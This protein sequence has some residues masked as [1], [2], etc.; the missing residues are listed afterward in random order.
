MGYLLLGMLSA[1][2]GVIQPDFAIDDQRIYLTE[3]HYERRTRGERTPQSSMRENASG[4]A[5]RSI[6]A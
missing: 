6:T 2:T 1:G 5:T 3:T 4:S